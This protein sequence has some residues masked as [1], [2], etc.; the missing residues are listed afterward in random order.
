VSSNS[1][2]DAADTRLSTGRTVPPLEPGATSS[3]TTTVTL[4]QL[5]PG[6]WYVL[7][8]ADDG[9]AVDESLENNNTKYWTVKVGPDLTIPTASVP[10]TG[11]SGG[12]IVVSHAVRNAGAQE[13]AASVVKYYLSTNT[14]LDTADTDLGTIAE[15]QAL[16]GG[17]TTTAGATLTIPPGLSGVFYVIISADGTH[18]VTEFTE[19]NNNAARKITIAVPGGTP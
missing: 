12:T 18:V 19:S 13:A 10:S 17:A 15:I 11:V 2:L 3:G 9:Q 16:A 8:R 1:T 14:T 4:P 7:A 5:T 6:T